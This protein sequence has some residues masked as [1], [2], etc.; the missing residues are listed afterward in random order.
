MLGL[1]VARQLN[2]AKGS[3]AVLSLTSSSTPCSRH[4]PHPVV[5]NVHHQIGGLA[6]WRAQDNLF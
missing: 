4:S 1:E 5:G 6:L 2:D 3:L